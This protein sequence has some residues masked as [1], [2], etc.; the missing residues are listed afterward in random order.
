MTGSV[1]CTRRAVSDGF[2]LRIKREY[3][4]MPG[5]RLT[6]AQAARLWSVDA[7]T[8]RAALR[9]LA[10]SGYVWRH[11]DDSYSLTESSRRA[12]AWFVDR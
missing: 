7:E 5:L 12:C 10:D 11:I 3:T 4:G 8:A 1:E 2:L 9:A 6:P